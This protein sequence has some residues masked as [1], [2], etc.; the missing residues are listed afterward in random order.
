MAE[1]TKA[2]VLKTV[3]LRAP[4]NEWLGPMNEA[5]WFEGASLVSATPPHREGTRGGVLV[6]VG[7]EVL[8]YLVRDER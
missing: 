5:P 3:V 2:T 1:W 7:A 4:V 6:M 8:S